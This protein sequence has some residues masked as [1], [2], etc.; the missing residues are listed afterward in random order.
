M[1]DALAPFIRDTIPAGYET[2]I[3]DKPLNR[4]DALIWAKDW[5]RR[6]FRPILIKSVFETDMFFIYGS[7]PR[8]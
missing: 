7:P 5:D 3:S 2:R 1:R 4:R 6:G 8:Y